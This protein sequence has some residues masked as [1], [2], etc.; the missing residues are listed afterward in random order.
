MLFHNKHC[1][2]INVV[3]TKRCFTLNA[4]NNKCCSKSFND[5]TSPKNSLSSTALPHASF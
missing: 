3:H 4:S 1:F 5:P 2:T